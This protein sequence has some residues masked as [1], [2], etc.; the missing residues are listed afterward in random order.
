MEG[1][2][3]STQGNFSLNFKFLSTQQQILLKTKRDWNAKCCRLKKS[4]RLKNKRKNR[5]K[6]I[7]Q[8]GTTDLLHVL[9]GGKVILQNQRRERF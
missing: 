4:Y 8:L 6:L 7:I 3:Y 9:S 1:L 2:V 5:F